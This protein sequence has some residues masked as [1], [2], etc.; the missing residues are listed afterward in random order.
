MTESPDATPSLFRLREGWIASLFLLGA[1]VTLFLITRTEVVR[2]APQ[3]TLYIVTAALFAV[4]IP[5]PLVRLWD[6]PAQLFFWNAMGW[7]A[8]LAIFGLASVGSLPIWPLI[9]ALLGLTFWPREPETTAPW[10]AILIA[11]M[12]GFL[13]CFMAWG[14]VVF[15]IPPEFSGWW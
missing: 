5:G 11:S 10:E 14:D 8:G 6:L 12:G 9:L 4:T 1:T 7:G 13:V 15:E 2:F 3:E